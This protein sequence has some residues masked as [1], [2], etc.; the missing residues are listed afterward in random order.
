MRTDCFRGDRKN[1]AK[2]RS[3]EALAG[4]KDWRAQE[5]LVRDGRLSFP[6]PLLDAY[7]IERSFDREVEWL[8]RVAAESRCGVLD[9]LSSA[10]RSW[11]L[12]FFDSGELASIVEWLKLKDQIRPGELAASHDIYLPKSIKNFIV[13]AV[14]VAD[15]AWRVVFID[16]SVPQGMLIAQRLE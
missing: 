5:L 9:D 10:G 14:V 12:V 15:P 6:R 11:D 4:R 2:H 8:E 3:V 1:V 7:S 16:S 13:C